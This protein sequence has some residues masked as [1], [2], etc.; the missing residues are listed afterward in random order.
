MTIVQKL[1]EEVSAGTN[2]NGIEIHFP[3]YKY[4][5]DI[6]MGVIVLKK[7]GEKNQ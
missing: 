7:R 5:L 2:D 4:D 3:Y 1:N 6:H